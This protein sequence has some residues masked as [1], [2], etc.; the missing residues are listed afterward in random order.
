MDEIAWYG[1]A[2]LASD[3][4]VFCAGT[5]AQCIRRWRRLSQDD[6][7][8]VTIRIGS[9]TQSRTVLSSDDIT[10]LANS[11]DLYRI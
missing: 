10:R 9:H 3:T 11:R 6:Q 4:R 1:E 7:S 8:Q 5:L 2:S